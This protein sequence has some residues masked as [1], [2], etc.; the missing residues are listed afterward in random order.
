MNI[1]FPKMIFRSV[2]AS[3][4]MRRT[5][6][7]RRFLLYSLYAWGMPTVLTTAT[8]CIDYYELMPD[9]WSPQMIHSN[10]CWFRR[11]PATLKNVVFSVVIIIFSFGQT[12]HWKDE[13]FTFC[14]RSDCTWPPIVCCS[15]W[16]RSIAVKWKVK[17]I[18]CKRKA[19]IRRRPKNVLSPIKPSMI[20]FC[21][22]VN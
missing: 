15:F 3:R 5:K 18:G 17:F 7:M 2:R 22:F 19:T 9:E 1:F 12:K 20:F 11:K 16:R 13:S 10:T 4:G 14:C 8:I 21:I 6:E